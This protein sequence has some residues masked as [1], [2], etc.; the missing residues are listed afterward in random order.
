MAEPTFQNSTARRVVKGVPQEMEAKVFTSHGSIYRASAVE[1]LVGGLVRRLLL[2]ANCR[3][4]YCCSSLPVPFLPS[5]HFFGGGAGG[6]CAV[7]V[8]AGLVPRPFVCMVGAGRPP[9]DLIS[10]SVISILYFPF[11]SGGCGDGAGLG[12]ALSPI[13]GLPARSGAGRLPY[14]LVAPAG[15]LTFL[16]NFTP[17]G[18]VT[19]GGSGSVRCYRIDPTQASQRS[20][21][22]AAV[23]PCFSTINT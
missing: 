3:L 6:F 12:P 2:A 14:V 18:C 11:G 9:S 4:E 20:L 5:A 1:E 23:K 10:R 7:G 15:P 17:G 21:S 8:G 19:W 13:P 16:I 22:N